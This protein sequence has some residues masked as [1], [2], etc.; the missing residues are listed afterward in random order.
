MSTDLSTDNQGNGK[1]RRRLFALLPLLAF[2]ALAAVFTLQLLSGRDNSVVPSAL[3][4]KPAPHT[5]LEPL[6]GLT[7]DGV[8]LPGLDPAAFKGQVTLVN[9]F[10]SW[11]PP[12]REEHPTFMELARDGRFGI[13]GLNYKDTNENALRFLMDLGNPYKAVGVDGNG[14]AG[15]EWGVYGPPETFLVGR[16]GTILFKHIG[17]VMPNVVTKELMPAIEKALAAK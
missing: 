15:I 17:P 7:R 8:Q 14:R 9:V 12:C 13:V 6:P 1:S 5:L 4:G 10:A 3:I 11:C 2:L 16:D